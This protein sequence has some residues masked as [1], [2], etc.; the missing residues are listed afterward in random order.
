MLIVAI[1]KKSNTDNHCNYALFGYRFPNFRNGTEVTGLHLRV[2][3][4]AKTGQ[5]RILKA[6]LFQLLYGYVNN[7]YE[8]L[9]NIELE[10]EKSNFEGLE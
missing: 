7:G 9:R 3:L 5:V 8:Q 1:G 2:D 4:A 6:F 10:N